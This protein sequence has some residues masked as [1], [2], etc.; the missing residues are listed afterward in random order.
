MPYWM[1]MHLS[2]SVWAEPSYQKLQKN[3]DL[4]TYLRAVT[5]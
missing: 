4:I 1:I 3:N 2:Y 5:T